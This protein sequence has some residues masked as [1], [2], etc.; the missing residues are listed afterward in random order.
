M[1]APSKILISEYKSIVMKMSK[2]LPTNDVATNNYELFCD[3]DKMMGLTCMLPML[4]AVQ[5]L[6]KLVQNKNCFIV[7]LW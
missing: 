6:N 2:D 5:N 1:M 7:I 3:V 4:E